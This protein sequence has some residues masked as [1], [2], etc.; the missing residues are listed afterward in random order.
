[1][2]DK[3]VEDWR[4][5]WKNSE[6]YSVDDGSVTDFSF[7]NSPMSPTGTIARESSRLIQGPCPRK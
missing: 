4:S 2:A 5:F 1:M 7:R 6:A 3:I